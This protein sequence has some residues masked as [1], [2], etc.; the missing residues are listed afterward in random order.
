[1]PPPCRTPLETLGWGGQQLKHIFTKAWSENQEPVQEGAH[2]PLKL[3][4]PLLGLHQE[5]SDSAH[6]PSSWPCTGSRCPR[7]CSGPG[8]TASGAQAA[9]G[10]LGARGRRAGAALSLLGP[11]GT[12]LGAPASSWEQP[13]CPPRPHAQA[14]LGAPA[15]SSSMVLTKALSHVLLAQASAGLSVGRHPQRGLAQGYIQPSAG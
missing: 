3:L 1:M 13:S 12:V 9:P 15:V 6:E 10:A 2:P 11:G 5:P 4:P 14:I 7:L 8:P